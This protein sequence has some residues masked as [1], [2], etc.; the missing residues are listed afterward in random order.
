VDDEAQAVGGSAQGF[1]PRRGGGPAGDVDAASQP[2]QLGKGRRALDFDQV[3]LLN[4]VSGVKQALGELAVVREQ[5]EPFA[6]LIQ[7]PDRI[8]A[9]DLRRRHELEHGRSAPGIA[10]RAQDSGRLVE[11]EV[12]RRRTCPQGGV[13]ERDRVVQGIGPV[14]EVG[15]LTVHADAP[16]LDQGLGVPARIDAGGRQD[17][18]QAFFCHRLTGPRARCRPPARLRTRS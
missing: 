5:D 6:L 3:F 11:R 9:R 17:L 1:H 13:V 7:T 4:A 14:A 2:L 10:H 16:G 8:G 15:D 18:L 12:D